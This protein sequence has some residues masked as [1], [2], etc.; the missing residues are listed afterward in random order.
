MQVEEN[1]PQAQRP[2]YKEVAQMIEEGRLAEA[3][4]WVFSPA[5]IEM[6]D[7]CECG[8]HLAFFSL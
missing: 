4:K 8:I 6:M 1:E 3:R 5:A 2:S 7:S